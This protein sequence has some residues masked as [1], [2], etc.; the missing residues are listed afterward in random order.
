MTDDEKINEAF[1]RYEAAMHAVQSGIALELELGISTN[2]TP[3]HLRL[4]VNSA[5]VEHSALASLLI[6]K[7]LFTK[8]DYACQ[9]AKFAELEKASYEKDLFEKLFKKVTLL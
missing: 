7:G 4:G 8:L 2:T 6:E 5:M 1:A 9:L 3:K